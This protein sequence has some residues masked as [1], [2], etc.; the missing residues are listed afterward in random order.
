MVNNDK[1][2]YEAYNL[3]QDLNT[4]A[5]SATYDTAREELTNWFKKVENSECHIEPLK[6]VVRTLKTWRTAIINSFI[7]DEEKIGLISNGC[8][9]A[10]NNTVKTIVKLGYGYKKPNL[11][12]IVVLAADRERTEQ[13]DKQKNKKYNTFITKNK[14]R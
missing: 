4:I 8:C 10:K 14:K 2:L 6:N 3:L 9:E 13:K 7:I 5:F 1:D 11:L 12:R